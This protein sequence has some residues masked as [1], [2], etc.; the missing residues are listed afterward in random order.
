MIPVSRNEPGCFFRLFYMARLTGLIQPASL[1][2]IN[3]EMLGLC[4]LD[5]DGFPKAAFDKGFG[6][7]NHNLTFLAFDEEGSL[8]AFLVMGDEIM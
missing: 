3:V 5:I 1:T 8:P 2:M 6:M 7:V 4:H